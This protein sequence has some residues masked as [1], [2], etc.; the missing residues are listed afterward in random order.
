MAVSF[1][2]IDDRMIHGLIT[3]RWGKEYPCD[4]IIAIND[5]AA[6]NPILAE[7]YKAAS[8][9]KTFVWTLEHFQQVKDKVL[10][11]ATK[12]FII[13]KNPQ[14]MKQILVDMQFKPGDIDTI[15][16]GPGNDRE[17]AIKLGDNQSFTQA[18]ADAFEEIEQAGYKVEFALLPDQRLG[19]WDKFKSRFG[20]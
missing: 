2:R 19:N 1:V 6:N 8:D 20:Y 12:Y 5:K 7:A 9:K 3:V 13:T 4:G 11:S 18:E 10:Q 14:D 15:I 17:N 16:V